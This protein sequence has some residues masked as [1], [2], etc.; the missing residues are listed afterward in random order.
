[1]KYGR[2]VLIYPDFYLPDTP[3][4]SITRPSADGNPVAVVT[5]KKLALHYLPETYSVD[6]KNGKIFAESTR[7][8]RTLE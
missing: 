5:M 4:S 2:A 7:M 8:P 6:R 3:D 1:M